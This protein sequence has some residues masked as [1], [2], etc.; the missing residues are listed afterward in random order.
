MGR[1]CEP[2]E[3]RPGEEA[4][5]AVREKTGGMRRKDR[6]TKGERCRENMKEGAEECDEV[7]EIQD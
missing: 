5:D 6:Q 3:W 7:E 4:G 1:L 2:G